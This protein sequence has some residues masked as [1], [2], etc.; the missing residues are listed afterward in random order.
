MNVSISVDLNV[1]PG[2]LSYLCQWLHG[3]TA[4]LTPAPRL[5]APRGTG[6]A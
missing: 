1:F 2:V 5:K 4:W 3:R 6:V